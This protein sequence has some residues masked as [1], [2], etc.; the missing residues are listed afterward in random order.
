LILTPYLN[1]VIRLFIAALCALGLAF[2]PV[3]AGAAPAS[4]DN[5]PGC[6]MGKEMPKKTGDHAKKDCCVPACQAPS[7][8]A[9]LP[10]N[11]DGSAALA[12]EPQLHITVPARELASVPNSGLD[13]PPK[14]L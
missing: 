14:R 8:A 3:A 10:Q 13:P 2:A 12:P 7:S 11:G 9:C 6:T 5:M 1:R 4:S